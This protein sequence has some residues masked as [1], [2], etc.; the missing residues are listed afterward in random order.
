MRPTLLVHAHVDGELDPANALAVERQIAGNPALAA[1][2][3]RIEALRNVLS[4]EFP[5]EALPPSSADTDRGR[6]RSASRGNRSVL[7][8]ARRIG[9]A[10]NGAG[11]RLDLADTASRL[12]RPRR[13]R[14]GRRSHAR[15]DGNTTVRRGLLRPPHRQ[16]VV[17]RPHP[18]GAAGRRSRS[19]GLHA[20]RRAHRCDRPHA[21]ADAGL[22]G[23]QASHQPAGGSRRRPHRR[24][25]PCAARSTATISWAGRRT[26]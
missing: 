14:G 24:M 17:Q 2:R 4:K 6:G 15:V 16:A 21:R 13:R 10:R 8:G 23:A 26:A 7:A 3:A 19:G 1:E 9:R 22:S 20:G 12:R 5:R 18:A 25:R 11:E